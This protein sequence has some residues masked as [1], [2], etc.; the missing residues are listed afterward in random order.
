MCLHFA[1]FVDKVVSSWSRRD[2]SWIHSTTATIV[3]SIVSHFSSSKTMMA[4]SRKKTK[5]KQKPCSLL[6]GCLC[7]NVATH[8]SLSTWCLHLRCDGCFVFFC[9]L[10]APNQNNPF[11][12][13]LVSLS[14]NSPFASVQFSLHLQFF[15]IWQFVTEQNAH[16]RKNK[17]PK[18]STNTNQRRN[19]A[20]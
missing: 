17:T 14:R 19:G 5:Q 12:K 20:F 8:V 13:K 15:P 3:V 18:Q 9:F 6:L 16:V 2:T 10:S 1:F 4:D 11:Y 7:R